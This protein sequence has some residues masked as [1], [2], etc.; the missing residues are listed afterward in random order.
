M[1]AARARAGESR[2]M[3][4]VQITEGPEVTHV[5]LGATMEISM[6]QALYR[7]LTPCLAQASALVVDASQ[8][9]RVDTAALQTLAYF[10]RCA[11]ERGIPFQWR[12]V[13]PALQQAVH[14]LGL[15]PFLF[16]NA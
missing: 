5:V 9:Q 16:E 7:Q 11:R 10:Y 15:A 4:T 8:V 6:A 13:S 3:D 14:S 1:S 2:D 12:A